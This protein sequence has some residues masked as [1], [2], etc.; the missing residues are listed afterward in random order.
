MYNGNNAH[1][2]NNN[3]DNNNKLVSTGRSARP[4][5]L[6]D[7]QASISIII[8]MTSNAYNVTDNIDQ[9]WYNETYYSCY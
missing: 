6:Q 2:H 1:D 4:I 3:D 7:G 9:L 8:N 5:R